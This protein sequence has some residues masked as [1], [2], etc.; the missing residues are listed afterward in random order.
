MYNK[1]NEIL[2]FFILIAFCVIVYFVSKNVIQNN[3]NSNTQIYSDSHNAV[4]NEDNEYT[5]YAAIAT[6]VGGIIG[7]GLGMYRGGY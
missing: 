2:I 7:S 3:T 5:M 1:N 4:Y 6:A